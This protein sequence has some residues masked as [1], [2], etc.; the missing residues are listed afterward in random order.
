MKAQSR[1]FYL[2]IG[3]FSIITAAISF[4]GCAGA[5]SSSVSPTPSP[6]SAPLSTSPVDRFVVCLDPGHPSENNTGDVVQNELKEVEINWQVAKRLEKLLD[7][8]RI[9]VVM[10]K[11]TVDQY[12]DN[13]TR[14]RIANQAAANLLV[15]LHCD[16]G[17]GRSQ[18]ITFYYPDRQGTKD[19]KTGPS[20]QIIEKSTTAAGVIHAKTVAVLAGVLKDNGV[21]GESSTLI[22][23]KQGALT[24]S[25]YSEMPVTTIEMVFLDNPSDARFIG[26]ENGQQKM[27]EALKEGILACL[28]Q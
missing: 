8:Q 2:M 22:G 20:T 13:Q 1:I 19:N 4:V 21:K 10:T 14:A 28:T 24:G 5:T 9:R 17:D 23:K 16:S 11:N 15:R 7:A 27:A 25:I 12:V 6:S 18:G 26:S 3:V